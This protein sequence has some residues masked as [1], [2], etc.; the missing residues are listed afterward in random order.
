MIVGDQQ[1]SAY[2]RAS[3]ALEAFTTEPQ[4]TND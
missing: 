1:V 4:F 3:G 2:S